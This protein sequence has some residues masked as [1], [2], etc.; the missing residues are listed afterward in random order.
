MKFQL[1]VEYEDGKEV[2]ELTEKETN[3]IVQYNRIDLNAMLRMAK[4][5]NKELNRGIEG[6]IKE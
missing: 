5:K 4:K 3:K 6:V 2:Y 1:E